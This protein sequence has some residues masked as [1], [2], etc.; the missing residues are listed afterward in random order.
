IESSE[1][2]RLRNKLDKR[3]MPL[4]CL[5]SFCFL[6]RVNVGFVSLA[7]LQKSL[8]LH[9]LE[10]NIGLVPQFLLCSC[11]HLTITSNLLGKHFGMGNWLAD[12]A[13]GFGICM[14]SAFMRNF[15]EF[16]LIRTLL[17]VFEGGMFPGIA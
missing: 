9:R 6:D 16:C 13:F 1:E 5:L 3:I 15:G 4:V 11:L 2:I 10:Y 7:G 14:C 8:D 12:S 17:G